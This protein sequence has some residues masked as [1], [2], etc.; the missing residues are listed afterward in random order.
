MA[1]FAVC[2]SC[3]DLA[4]VLTVADRL[5]H[6]SGKYDCTPSHSPTEVKTKNSHFFRFRRQGPH[7]NVLSYRILHF[8]LDYSRKKSCTQLFCTFKGEM[9]QDLHIFSSAILRGNLYWNFSF[10]ALKRSKK[11]KSGKTAE[12]FTKTFPKWPRTLT[13]EMELRLCFVTSLLSWKMLRFCISESSV[14]ERFWI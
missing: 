1:Y 5:E 4:F 9:K 12:G 14:G 3:N 2:T 11:V 13:G 7:K 6:G 8:H 10:W